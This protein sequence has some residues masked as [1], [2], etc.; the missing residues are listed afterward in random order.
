MAS[1]DG[2]QIMFLL[3]IE[4]CEMLLKLWKKVIKLA[5]CAAVRCFCSPII[6]QPKGPITVVIL[7]VGCFSNWFSV[8]VN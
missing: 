7:P 5:I 4:S 2:M 6:P 8:Y 1:G 3:T